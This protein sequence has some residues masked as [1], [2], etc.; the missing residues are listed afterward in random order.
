[1]DTVDTYSVY[2]HDLHVDT[3][4]MTIQDKSINDI[5]KDQLLSASTRTINTLKNSAKGEQQTQRPQTQQ[6]QRNELK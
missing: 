2:C 6:Q 1:M 5:I 3:I 4:D